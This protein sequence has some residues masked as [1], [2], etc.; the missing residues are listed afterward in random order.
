VVI[1]Y[2][3]AGLNDTV[4]VHRAELHCPPMRTLEPIGPDL[5]GKVIITGTYATCR[6]G[7]HRRR[8]RR[9]HHR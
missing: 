6:P 1:S 8:Y 7:L 5:A 2:S 3:I 9:L 4:E